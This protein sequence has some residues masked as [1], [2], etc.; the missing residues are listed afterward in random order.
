MSTDQLWRSGTTDID[1]VLYPRISTG[2][3]A[4]GA[5]LGALRAE[6]AI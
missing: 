4:D 6:G 1:D 5:R 2:R 3:Q